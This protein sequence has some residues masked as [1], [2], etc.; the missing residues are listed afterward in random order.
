MIFTPTHST[1][2]LMIRSYRLA[3]VIGLFLTL[4]TA[5][6][7]WQ[8]PGHD[9]ITIDDNV[10]VTNNSYVAAGLTAKSIGWA[11][12][13]VKA[14]FWHPLTWL[15][16]MADTQIFGGS[17]GGYHLTNLLLHII[18][19]LLL[20]F[21]LTK[22]TGNLWQ[23]GIAASLFA[24]HPL[25]VE[26]VAWIAQRKDVLSTFFWLL[27][28]WCYAHFVEKPNRSRYGWV[29]VFFI[30][31]LMSKPMLLTLPFTLLLLDY[32][33][34]RRFQYQGPLGS[35]VRVIWPYIR[36]K[37]PLWGIAA[38]AAIVTYLAQQHGGG[39]DSQN[40]YPLSDRI[41]NAL[42]S[43][44]IYIWKMIWPQNLAF[45]YPFPRNLPIWQIITST[46]TLGFIT[47]WA[48]K[49]IKRQPYIIVGWLWYLGT[50]VPVIG[51]VKIG[52]FSMGDRYTYVPLIGLFIILAWGLPDILEKWRH[53]AVALGLAASIAV[54]GLAAVTWIQTQHW[55]NSITLYT[56]ALRA[57]PNNFLAHYALGDILAGEGKMNESIPHFADAVKIRPEKTT[58]RNALGRALASQ[59][60]FDEAIFHLMQAL[61][62]KPD[63]AE[64][65]YNAGLVL[66]AQGQLEKSI[67]HFS[68]ALKLHPAFVQAQHTHPP[69]AMSAHFR[70]AK[71]FEDEG[72]IDKAIREYKRALSDRSAYAP[73]LIKVAKLYAAKKNYARALAQYQ[74][75]PT[76]AGLKRALLAGYQNWALIKYLS[77]G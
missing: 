33:P 71:A 8:L 49:S 5:G 77:I 13:T 57:T 35:F 39:L 56:H 34:F 7:F 65:H 10:Y 70:R 40:P 41:A 4:A 25:H 27:T 59:G 16:L 37:L 44:G 45:F 15:S 23:S 30:L 55:S 69:M 20:F 46:I 26:S 32:W 47:A 76:P 28:L 31:G 51:L 17:P 50:L 29:L 1:R 14:E 74:I 72:D 60:R 12:T 43:Y 73:A 22:A 36:E 11:F 38:V 67:D 64:S 53:K 42:L 75:D 48:L 9:F 68:A 24:L 19:T 58:L 3:L 52:D 62:I 2:P 63:K 21:F 66:A 54:T 6:V 18:N 61:R